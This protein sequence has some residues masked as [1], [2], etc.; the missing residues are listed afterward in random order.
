M[1]FF[2]FIQQIL[3]S[4][5]CLDGSFGVNN[6]IVYTLYG[7]KIDGQ[8]FNVQCE[9]Y[10][11]VKVG[12]EEGEIIYKN[13]ICVLTLRAGSESKL[14]G[15]NH[16]KIGCGNKLSSYKL[17][18]IDSSSN[19]KTSQFKNYLLKGSLSDISD[20]KPCD[21]IDKRLCLVFKTRKSRSIEGDSG[22]FILN[23]KN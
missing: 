16:L 4:A 10:E 17:L 8:H 6:F 3:T 20:K 23:Q 13:D 12:G 22:K 11:K 15:L 21:D 18:S 9:Q 1:N 7:N 14:N 19:F 2:Q 5:H